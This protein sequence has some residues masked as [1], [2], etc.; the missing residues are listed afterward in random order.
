MASVTFPEALGGNGQTYT[1][2][3]DPNTGLDGLGYTVRFI[4]CLQQAVIMGLSAQSNAQAAAG[5]V[6]QCQTL[7]EEVASVLQATQQAASSANNSASASLEAKLA[8]EA[9]YGDLAAVDAAKGAAEQAASD[10]NGQREL[11]ETAADQSQQAAAQAVTEHE[12]K[13]DPHSQYEKKSALSMAAYR[14]TIGGGGAVFAFA[15]NNKTP[16]INLTTFN[17][18]EIPSG[19]WTTSGVIADGPLGN[20]VHT[21]QLEVIDRY[22]DNQVIHNWYSRQGSDRS[23]YTRSGDKAGNA[24]GIWRKVYDQQNVL[25]SVSQSGG[26]PTGAL[27]ERDSNSFGEFAKFAD[28]S[29]E[30]IIN[31]SQDLSVQGSY[32]YTLPIAFINADYVTGYSYSNTTSANRHAAFNGTLVLRNGSEQVRVWITITDPNTTS[33]SLTIIVKGRWY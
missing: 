18:F 26:T 22:F 6:Q 10:A 25:G 4:P 14:E 7:R 13:T 23:Q 15:E 19:I 28:G 29:A 33:W 3:A 16:Q 21:G 2:D 11:A 20:T 30:A 24:W 9:L 17:N 31:V 5:Y 12:A 8:A 27:I 32:L 1:D